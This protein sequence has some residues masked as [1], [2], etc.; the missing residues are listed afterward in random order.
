L[1]IPFVVIAVMWFEY[2]VDKSSN[3]VFV[4]CPAQIIDYAHDLNDL[5]KSLSNPLTLQLINRTTVYGIFN[6]LRTLN[7]TKQEI[8]IREGLHDSLA[9]EWS[10]EQINSSQRGRKIKRWAQKLGKTCPGT[11]CNHIKFELLSSNQMAF[12]HVIS[13]K[14]IQSFTFLLDK[15]DHPDNLYL[16]CNQCNSQLSDSFPDDPLRDEIQKRGTIGDWLRSD[17]HGIM[18]S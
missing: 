14:W 18:A 10:F 4:A 7:Q 8:P 12:G 17:L 2:R 11:I 9:R 13:Q 3:L 16:T 15:K 1:K 5:G 6:L